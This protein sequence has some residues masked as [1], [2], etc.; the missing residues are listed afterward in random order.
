MWA[1]PPRGKGG[2]IYAGGVAPFNDLITP[3]NTLVAAGSPNNCDSAVWSRG[4]NLESA[5]TCGFTA[6]GDRPNA[7]PL[8]GPLQNNGGSTL[9]HAPRFGS[10]TMDAANNATCPATDQRGVARPIDGNHDG[11]A[12]CDI[13]A[14]E[15]PPLWGVFLP[16]A[17]RN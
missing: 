11:S 12:V 13:G 10:P 9:T 1:T 2:N 17:R 8:L 14:Y 5:N 15:A 3:W 4:Y 7:N 6:T 16:M